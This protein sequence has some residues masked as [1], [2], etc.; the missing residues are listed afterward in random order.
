MMSDFGLAPLKHE[1]TIHWTDEEG[2]Q[3]SLPVAEYLTKF[4]PLPEQE[5]CYVERRVPVHLEDEIHKLIDK[6]LEE[7]RWED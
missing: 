3:R 6:F 7:E 4:G 5:T 1:G 2:I